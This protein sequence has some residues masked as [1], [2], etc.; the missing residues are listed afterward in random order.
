M[1]KIQERLEARSIDQKRLQEALEYCLM[2]NVGAKVAINTG[3]FPGISAGRLHYALKNKMTKQ[4]R[5]HP[6]QILTNDE[7]RCLASWILESHDNGSRSMS[8]ENIAA[9]VILILKGR[10][11][12]NKKRKWRCC[13]SLNMNEQM[14]VRKVT[15]LSLLFFKSFHAWC[16]VQGI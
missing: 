12:S 5:D 1:V 16:R 14:C 11:A 6:R 2:N 13:E 8:N 10:H 3:L 7:R 4:V 9:K 15:E